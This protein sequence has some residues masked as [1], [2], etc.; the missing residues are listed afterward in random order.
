[1]AVKKADLLKKNV[2]KTSRGLFDGIEKLDAAKEK[3]EK[4]ETIKEENNNNQDAK[5]ND[6][7]ETEQISAE[8]VQAVENTG[9]TEPVAVD[10]A[11]DAQTPVHEA[12]EENKKETALETMVKE[13]QAVPETVINEEQ[14]KVLEPVLPVESMNT[15]EPIEEQ[16]HKEE[17]VPVNNYQAEISNQTIFDNSAAA[18]N[19]N[20]PGTQV[21]MINEQGVNYNGQRNYQ[22]MPMSQI[23]NQS[24]NTQQM[25]NAQI[26]NAQIS[27]AQ[28]QN[29]Q[30]TSGQMPGAQVPYYQLPNNMGMYPNQ[31]QQGNMQPVAPMQPNMQQNMQQGYYE[32]KA[33]KKATGS[34]QE[35]GSR[36]EKDKF[37]LLD[38]RGL[39]DYVEHMAKASNLSATKYIRKLIEEDMHRNMDIYLRHKELEEQ[40]KQRR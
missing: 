8:T 34:K 29:V 26:S 18:V 27:N 3:A 11:V 36:Y 24:M 28:M 20:Y 12:A 31:L 33:E 15:S 40:L 17:Y 16:A 35:K 6:V 25:P 5:V 9:E 7:S 32:P 1:M 13:Q 19:Q 2:R 23:Q 38:I 14:P 10:S 39:R 37:L 30:A 21:N 22:Q 4:N